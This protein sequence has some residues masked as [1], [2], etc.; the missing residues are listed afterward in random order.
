ML[1]QTDYTFSIFLPSSVFFTI[2][3]RLCNLAFTIWWSAN[4]F[5]SRD[6]AEKDGQSTNERS[7]AKNQNSHRDMIQIIISRLTMSDKYF[8]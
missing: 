5:R 7:I 8:H 1:R 4:G 6:I 3:S 2:E